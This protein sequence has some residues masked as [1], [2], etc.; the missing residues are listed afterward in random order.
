MRAARARIHDSSSHRLDQSDAGRA[1]IFSQRTFSRRTN[2]TQDARVY[3]RNC[4]C[5]PVI[6]M[7]ESG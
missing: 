1:G 4:I 5:V 7:Q 3:S 6:A 2:R